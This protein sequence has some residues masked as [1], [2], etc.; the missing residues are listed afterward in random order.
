MTR[1]GP[2]GE[3]SGI[4]VLEYGYEHLEGTIYNTSP[5]KKPLQSSEV[6]ITSELTSQSPQTY[7]HTIQITDLI[8]SI[9]ENI[10]GYRSEAGTSAAYF[11]EGYAQSDYSGSSVL[12]YDDVLVE[13][14]RVQQEVSYSTWAESRTALKLKFSP[15]TALVGYWEGD[16]GKP[17][18]PFIRLQD[19]YYYQIFSYLIYTESD[20][21]V[22]E[23]IR[24]LLSPAGLAP[25]FNSNKKFETD[26]RPFVNITRTISNERL[27][28]LDV[29]SLGEQHAIESGLYKEDLIDSITDVVSKNAALNKSSE[30]GFSD[31]QTRGVG[32][33]K[34]DAI[35]FSESVLRD[36]EFVLSDTV[37]IEDDN[38]TRQIEQILVDS[39]VISDSIA[40]SVELEPF[41][42]EFVVY[43]ITGEYA[44]E[45]F[46]EEYSNS[47][48][49]NINISVQ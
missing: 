32:L 25:F 41:V 10:R 30:F 6:S 36:S 18:N 19:N 23:E 45:Y 13:F 28:L 15:K 49:T 31:S 22:V 4:E 7:S 35:G 39:Q 8:D 9:T 27:Y 21:G 34:I 24:K 2:N 11:L 42:V 16:H 3:L 37:S 29:F 20:I 46:S 44:Y 12:E 47:N 40:K 1:V 5:F 48:K 17:S 43:D 14:P 26:I 33:G 38:L